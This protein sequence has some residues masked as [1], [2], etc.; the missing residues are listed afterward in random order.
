MTSNVTFE[1]SFAELSNGHEFSIVRVFTLANIIKTSCPIFFCAMVILSLIY[2]Y[3][4]TLSTNKFNDFNERRYASANLRVPTV[5]FRLPRA[6]FGSLSR[7]LGPS[8][9]HLGPSSWFS[10]PL[11]WE[12]PKPMLGLQEPTWGT[13]EPTRGSQEPT[14]LF[15]E[16]TWRS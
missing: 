12:P 3:F 14:W 9:R 7:L 6:N 5:Y 11:C 13:Q 2:F 16:P 10:G 1:R 15:Q 4:S 8:S